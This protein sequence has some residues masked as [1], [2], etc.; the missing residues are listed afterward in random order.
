[1][2]TTMNNTLQNSKMIRILQIILEH[3]YLVNF[4]AGIGS[5]DNCLEKQTRC[6]E[7]VSMKTI[8]I[9]SKELFCHCSPSLILF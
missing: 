1:M 2:K 3:K 6:L 8:F 9:Y 7:V 4:I 5:R